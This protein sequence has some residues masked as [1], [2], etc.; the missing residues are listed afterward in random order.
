MN[1]FAVYHKRLDSG[2]LLA[3]NEIGH[4]TRLFILNV[5][6]GI[7]PRYISEVLRKAGRDPAL[8]DVSVSSISIA[9]ESDW[10]LDVK[11]A[12]SSTGVERID[13]D[14]LL[15]DSKGA[16]RITIRISPELFAKVQSEAQRREQSLNNFCAEA[17]QIQV[18]TRSHRIED[19]I[20]EAFYSGMYSESKRSFRLPDLW[21]Y[22][23]RNIPDCK[24]Q[25]IE[26]ALRRLHRAEY[27]LLDKWDA[28]IQRFRKYDGTDDEDFFYRNDFRLSI[29]PAGK[30]YAEALTGSSRAIDGFL[31]VLRAEELA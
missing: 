29:T 17:L 6:D 24:T 30:S 1:T 19:E 20:F 27:L 23:S 26:F 4:T 13:W 14:A 31:K 8:M 28:G 5:P 7:P 15:E 2:F 11:N 9:A 10:P 25:E 3:L 18:G 12:Q 21:Q 16:R 22:V